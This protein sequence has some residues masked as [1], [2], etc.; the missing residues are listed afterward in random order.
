MKYVEINFK[1]IFCWTHTWRC[2]CM[3]ARN[4]GDYSRR[5]F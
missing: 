1:C 2:F 4:S 5:F 3:S